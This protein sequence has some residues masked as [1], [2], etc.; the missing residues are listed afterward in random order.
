MEATPIRMSSL[1]LGQTKDLHGTL[2]PL[3]DVGVF[4]YFS[5][6]ASMLG[7]TAQE[8]LPRFLFLQITLIATLFI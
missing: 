3:S 7:F 5:S 8:V 4:M 2:S 1:R 6:F